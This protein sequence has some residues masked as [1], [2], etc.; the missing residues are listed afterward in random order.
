M[1]FEEVPKD[2]TWYK[3]KGCAKCNYTGYKGRIAVGELWTVSAEDKSLMNNK[4]STETIRNSTNNI[5]TMMDDIYDKLINKVTT[6]QEIIRAIPDE[7]IRPSS[8]YSNEKS[9]RQLNMLPTQATEMNSTEGGALR[10]PLDVGTGI[11]S[12]GHSIR[13]DSDM[14][15]L[16]L[17]RASTDVKSTA[18]KQAVY[19][20]IK[21]SSKP[22]TPKDIATRT[23]F[24]VQYVK[25]TLPRLLKEGGIK[26]SGEHGKYVF[27]GAKCDPAAC[28]NDGCIG[29]NSL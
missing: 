12:A 11:E 5:I 7:H 24:R 27:S 18:K 13:L 19:D 28:S 16:R 9:D 20:A 15:R 17:V 6:V 14:P 22:I 3:G 26:K 29:A 4:I 8:K 1:L 23:G 21:S 10:P 2:I 25:N